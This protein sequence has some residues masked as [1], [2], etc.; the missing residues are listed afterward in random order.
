MLIARLLLSYGF[1][2][3][4]LFKLKDMQATV[5]WF[6]SISIP[7]SQI[8]AYIVTGIETIGIVLLILGLFTRY[9]SL[10]LA[11]VMMGAI[12]FVHAGHG[13]SVADNGIEIPLYYMI[14]LF[15]FVSFGAGKYS[16]DNLFF[17]DANNE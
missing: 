15:L 9:I 1:A 2:K 5:L 11:F 7:F 6:E 4:A 8:M 10:L 12:F 16:L 13:F 3:P 17:K 14:F